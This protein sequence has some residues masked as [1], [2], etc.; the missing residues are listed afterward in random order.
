[1]TK[2][3]LIMLLAVGSIFG[4]IYGVK[5]Y[6][7]SLRGRAT[8]S[9]ETAAQTISVTTAKKRERIGTVRAVGSIQA[10]KG[11]EIAAQVAGVISAIHFE[12]GA[13]V[14]RGVLLVE[15]EATDEI[16]K[17][18]AQSAIAA[19]SKITYERDLRQLRAGVVSQQV[20]DSAREISRRD[21][22][23]VEQQRAIL[24]YKSIRAP[25]KGGLGIRR[26]SVGQYL[27]AGA[28]IVTLQAV[29]FVYL[30]FYLPQ[31]LIGKVKLG[32]SL[33]ALIDAYP[34]RHFSGEISAINRKVESGSRNIEVQ[35]TLKNAD[36][37]LVPGMFAAIEIQTEARESSIAV[38]H[39]AVNYQPHGNTVFVVERIN[40]ARRGREKIVARE[41][42]VVTGEGQGDQIS[43]I[44]GIKDGDI[45]VTGGQ[46]KLTSGTLVQIDNSL[47][48]SS[49]AN[50]VPV[51][52]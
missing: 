40:D 43:I 39:T 27:E 20:L 23:L 9:M 45:V 16:S 25:F 33:V 46:S 11:V 5:A 32:Q 1:M 49:D 24:G 14:E 44:S 2:P 29:D 8:A 21:A 51:D 13:E 36:H 37:S 47:A 18:E 6:Q 34:D 10:T 4:A 17:L 7:T 35:A 41:V 52:Q 30:N 26:V 38:P 50:P 12:S 15:M 3:M 19:L 28:P 31:N 22:A 48:P 42:A